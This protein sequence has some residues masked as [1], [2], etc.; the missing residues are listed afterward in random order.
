[1]THHAP[2]VVCEAASPVHAF[3]THPSMVDFPD[4]N[5]AVFF[6]S[7]CNF[8]CGYCHNAGLLAARQEG[9]GWPQLRRACRQF[10]GDW[11]RGAVIT[12]G[13]PTLH[14]ELDD[15]V[16][17]LKDEGFRVKLDTNGSRPEV[18]SRLLPQLDY[19]AMDIKAPLE[20]YPQFTGFSDT[21]CIAE[22][23]ALLRDHDGDY[24]FR[25]TVIEG[26][27]TDARM[28]AIG[29]LVRGARRQVLQPFLPRPNLPDERCRARPRTSHT[30]LLEVARLLEGT[31]RQIVVRG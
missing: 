4:E 17:F 26:I 23:V 21:G 13:E 2:D 30:R 18:L 25:T 19:T 14:D 11:V 9:I 29:E 6:V 22:S 27:H 3:L 10:G 31:A 7:G 16:A 28:R 8:R 24:E 1:M 5:A 20:D 12:G 15:L